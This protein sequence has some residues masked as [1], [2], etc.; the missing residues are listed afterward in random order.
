MTSA[1]DRYENWLKKLVVGKDNLTAQAK[2]RWQTVSWNPTLSRLDESP[3]KEFYKESVNICGTY[4]GV[5]PDAEEELARVLR[6]SLPVHEEERLLNAIVKIS[7]P[8]NAQLDKRDLNLYQAAL[9]TGFDIGSARSRVAADNEAAAIDIKIKFDKILSDEEKVELTRLALEGTFLAD[10]DRAHAAAKKLMAETKAD[11]RDPELAHIATTL[12]LGFDATSAI[13][14]LTDE[15]KYSARAM[16]HRIDDLFGEK[17][18]GR[19]EDPKEQKEPKKLSQK[20]KKEQKELKALRQL[21]K[22]SQR[23]Y[24]LNNIHRLDVVK[25]QFDA[26]SDDHIR[27][28]RFYEIA[29]NFSSVLDSRRLPPPDWQELAQLLIDNISPCRQEED[30]RG[31]F[32][33]LIYC[34]WLDEAGLPWSLERLADRIEN[35]ASGPNRPLQAIHVSEDKEI[36][37]VI[38]RYASIWQQGHLAAVDERR[39][40]YHA[41]YGFPLYIARR[42]GKLDTVDPRSN[43]PAA[44]HQFLSNAMRYY[45]DSQNLD[46]IPDPQPAITSLKALGDMLKEGNENLRIVR[47]PELRGQFEYTKKVLGGHWQ[48][49]ADPLGEEWTNLLPG[50]PGKIQDVDPWTFVVDTVAT[51]YGWRRSPTRNYVTLAETGELILILSRWLTR[52]DSVLNDGVSRAFLEILKDAVSDYVAAFRNVARVDLSRQAFSGSPAD[53]MSASQSVRPPA[54][55]PARRSWMAELPMSA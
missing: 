36:A 46:R 31:S 54:V 47:S 9:V 55:P 52:D 22:D 49:P 39:K 5:L 10:D 3:V 24:V 1:T 12:V 34:Y 51:M 37:R 23:S 2:S 20:E 43:F 6:D 38:N 25:E 48:E 4:D 45:R 32:C 44:F 17:E 13:N 50:R 16:K 33:S 19:E 7:E 27:F 30:C 26:R 21:A 29:E 28:G 14:L 41:L 40:Q 8:H 11:R 15:P 53:A 18:Q 42:W 35:G